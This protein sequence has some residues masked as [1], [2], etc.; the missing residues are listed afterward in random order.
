[1]LAVTVT[2]N[3]N[4]ITLD[5]ASL[6][7]NIDYAVAPAGAVVLASGASQVYTVTFHP[8]SSGPH[9]ATLNIPS[10]TQLPAPL[11]VSLSGSGAAPVASAAPNPDRKSTRLNS[12]HQI[13]SY[14]VFCLKQ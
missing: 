5:A 12:S 2:N 13:S 14:A 4:P 7:N 9:G 10:S 11:Q 1:G 8:K 6:T 3:A